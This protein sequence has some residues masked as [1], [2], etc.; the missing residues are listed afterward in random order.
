MNWTKFFRQNWLEIPKSKNRGRTISRVL[1][2]F[3]IGLFEKKVNPHGFPRAI[4][5]CFWS[6]FIEKFSFEQKLKSCSGFEKAK[7]EGRTLSQFFSIVFLEWKAHCL[8]KSLNDLKIQD[9]SV[10]F[11]Y[12]NFIYS[13][14]AK[15]TSNEIRLQNVTLRLPK[16]SFPE[17]TKQLGLRSS[18][19]ARSIYNRYCRSGFYLPKKRSGS[20]EKLPKREQRFI[21]RKMRKNPFMSCKQLLCEYNSF[22]AT[23]S[24]SELRFAHSWHVIIYPQEQQRTRIYFGKN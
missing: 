18:N 12:P 17:I 14:M 9:A 21:L 13:T 8:I 10:H 7:T 20:P 23:T 2:V 3:S 15:Q 11:V 6:L 22:A 24:V 19:T 4:N 16:L 1:D 5:E